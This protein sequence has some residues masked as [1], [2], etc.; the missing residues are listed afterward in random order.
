MCT[1]ASPSG[2]GEE[3]A[4]PGPNASAEEGSGRRLM[5]SPYPSAVSRRNGHVQR[6]EAGTVTGC[7][8]RRRSRP[9][10]PSSAATDPDLA[11]IVSTP[12]PA[13]VLGPRTGVSD[14]RPAD[15]RAAGRSPPREAAYDRLA[16]RSTAHP[17]G[18]PRTTDEELRAD[19]F[20]RQKTATSAR[21][22]P[23]SRTVTRSPGRRGAGRRRRPHRSRRAPRDRPWTAEVYLLSALR[24]PD[25]WPIGDIALQEAARRALGLASDRHRTSSSGSASRGARTARA[26]LGSGTSTSASLGAS[27]VLSGI[28]TK[29]VSRGRRGESSVGQATLTGPGGR[30]GACGSMLGGSRPNHRS[31]SRPLSLA[32]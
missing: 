23:R 5:S 32:S 1:L 7:S 31:R 12:R 11:A 21:S 22:P 17:R 19:G 8:T 10:R 27:R 16:A 24:R 15:P 14:A 30:P 20:S 2:E 3:G 26:Q 28:R 18:H 25:T 13:R 9:P 4:A 29:P 6:R